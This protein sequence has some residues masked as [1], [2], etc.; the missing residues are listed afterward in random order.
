LKGQCIRSNAGLY[1]DG[2]SEFVESLRAIEHNRWLAASLGKNGRQYYRDHYD[3]PV[4]ERKYLEMIDRLSKTA[5]STTIDPIPGWFE[6]QKVQCPPGSQV[7]AALPSGPSITEEA[8]LPRPEGVV[9]P[10][11]P[12]RTGPPRRQ[13]PAEAGP[14][15]RQPA[16]AAPDNRLSAEG[17]PPDRRDR[18][19]RRDQRR[20][21]RPRRGGGHS[22]PGGGR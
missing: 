22:R 3:W 16:D 15:N 18:H 11:L 1:Y 6:R 4:I 9:S 13:G 12:E 7:V 17:G 21:G 20:Y 2:Q 8:Y 19:D 5:P 14:H 10:P